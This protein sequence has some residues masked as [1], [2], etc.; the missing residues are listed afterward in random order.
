MENEDRKRRPPVTKTIQVFEFGDNF[1]KVLKS[2]LT[3]NH[4]EILGRLN[5]I[6]ANQAEFD[7][8]ITTANAALD[9]IQQK[10]T[11][12]AQ[13]VADFIA[14]NPQIDTSALT[15][16]VNRLQGVGASVENVFTPPVTE[17]SSGGEPT[18]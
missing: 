13:Q 1:T 16:V 2:I 8:Q 11:A 6:M 17:P 18:A 12:E 10:V 7:E 9:D 3:E 14:A 15:G 5:Q 4:N